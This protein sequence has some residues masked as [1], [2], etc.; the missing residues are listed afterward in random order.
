MAPGPLAT[1]AELTTQSVAHHGQGTLSLWRFWKWNPLRL[2]SWMTIFLRRT[3]DSHDEVPP[4]G[5]RGRL[6]N[7]CSLCWNQIGRWVLVP[8]CRFLRQ[9]SGP[10]D[11]TLG[12]AVG[13]DDSSAQQFAK[14][15]ES[16]TAPFQYAL[17]TRAGCE[18][19]S[20]A[21]Q[22]LTGLDESATILSVDGVGAFDLV[23]LLF[24]VGGRDGNR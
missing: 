10:T 24:L 2:S 18:C 3:F 15:V 11:D 5:R 23:L 13:T 19:V 20:H 22:S 4:L 6:Q 14:K 9:G 21:L 1:L 16:A 7:I 8:S 17:S 12:F